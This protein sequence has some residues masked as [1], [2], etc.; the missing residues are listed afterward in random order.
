MLRWTARDVVRFCLVALLL[1][2]SGYAEPSLNGFWTGTMTRDGATQEIRLRVSGNP[3]GY[4]ANFDW[5]DSGYFHEDAISMKVRDRDVL[6]SL[7]MPRG[8]LKLAGTWAGDSVAGGLLEIANVAGAWK[9]THTDGSFRLKRSRA[10]SLPYRLEEVSFNDGTVT[11]AGSLLIPRGGG[12][13]PAMTFLHGGG[14]ETR[15][16]GMF[17][18]D[19]LA[20]RGIVVLLYDKRGNG[21][22][23]GDWRQGGF[24]EMADDGAAALRVLLARP[25]V[26]AQRTGLV[27]YSQ[28]CWIA[29]LAISR[30]APAQFLVSISGPT[31]TV[32]DEGFAQYGNRMRE[33]GIPDSELAKA[34]PLLKLDNSVSKGQASWEDLQAQ[35][36]KDKDQ[37]WY[38]AIN[39]SPEDMNDPERR[40]YGKILAYDP[41]AYIESLK[42]PSLW[43][44]GTADITIPA[45]ASWER[46]RAMSVSPK[47]R[48]V[49]MKNADH[50]MTVREGG[51]LPTLADGFP[52]MIADW[53][54]KRDER[55]LTGKMRAEGE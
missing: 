28:G 8:A 30:G 19:T 24:E 6:V 52:G 46:L 3:D 26:D 51:K 21:K 13:H 34:L 33:A 48:I 11:L 39:W 53:I 55:P 43:L 47:P 27:C 18:G 54:H 9:T 45:Q 10:P 23:S 49:V 5:P 36:A 17:I 42:I 38:K 31:V 40:F 7:P 35:M 12:R 22:S 50:A 1:P 44:F 25:D 16:D 20:R 41:K 29:P 4:K 15:G 37:P 2:C 32:E 14:D